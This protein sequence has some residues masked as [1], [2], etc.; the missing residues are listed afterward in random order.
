MEDIP[1][2][3]QVPLVLLQQNNGEIRGKTRFQK[4]VF[5]AEEEEGLNEFY[6]FEK[7]NYGPYS[8]DLTDQLDTLV[9]LGFI[10]KYTKTFPSDG[11]FQGKKFIYKLTDEGKEKARNASQEIKEPL[12]KS[13]DKWDSSSASLDS[14]LDYVYDEYM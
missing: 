14:L 7:Y 4:M 5:L 2:R 12:K 13:A 3:L 6:E 11:K 9:E 8:F 1:E 10:E